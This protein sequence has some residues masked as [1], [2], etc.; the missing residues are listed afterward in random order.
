MEI[1]EFKSPNPDWNCTELKCEKTGIAIRKYVLIDDNIDT[2]EYQLL[3]KDDKSGEVI[4][5]TIFEILK[6]LLQ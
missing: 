6:T 1:N 5:E 2:V 4:T 3:N